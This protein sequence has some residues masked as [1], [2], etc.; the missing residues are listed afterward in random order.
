MLRYIVGRLAMIIP[1]LLGA[2]LIVFFMMRLGHGDPALDYLR[3]SQIPPTDEALAEV[4]E[5]LGLNRP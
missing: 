2:S 1:M 5:R 4:R 3:L